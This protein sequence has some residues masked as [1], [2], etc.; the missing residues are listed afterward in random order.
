MMMSK[1][2]PPSKKVILLG[3]PD[4]VKLKS[5]K[6]IIETLYSRAKKNP[7][8]SSNTY[9]EYLDYLLEQIDMLGSEDVD[10][11]RDS[12][13]IES[14]IYDAL[15]RMKWLKVINAFLVG[16]ITTNIGV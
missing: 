1:T 5:K 8:L 2:T 7:F 16:V 10:I 13:D 4:A 15:K 11:D 6:Y 9:D 12:D 3:F 14:Q